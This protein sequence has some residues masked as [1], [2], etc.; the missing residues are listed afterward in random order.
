MSV[1]EA[2]PKIRACLFDMDGVFISNFS[3][4][5]GLLIDSEGVYTRVTNEFLAQH[6]KGPLTAEVKA[7]LM[8]NEA[9]VDKAKHRPS[10]AKGSAFNR[11]RLTM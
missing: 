9:L 4:I 3:L 10:R 1:A 5:L 11:P 6:G 2:P 8:G 7:S